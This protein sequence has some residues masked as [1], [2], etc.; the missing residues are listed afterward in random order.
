M[1]IK[2]QMS[3]VM[4]CHHFYLLLDWK[5]YK[6]KKHFLLKSKDSVMG[7]MES[8]VSAWATTKDN[9]NILRPECKSPLLQVF[10]R[11][12]WFREIK[13]TNVT[14]TLTARLHVSL[15]RFTLY[16]PEWGHGALPPGGGV[17]RATECKCEKPKA[18]RKLQRQGPRK[19]HSDVKKKERLGVRQE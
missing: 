1:K 10:Y 4:H 19:R 14:L 2:L 16:L 9:S 8:Q 12:I 3:H 6:K 13:S 5:Q 17:E 11:Y 15:P 18:G 7:A